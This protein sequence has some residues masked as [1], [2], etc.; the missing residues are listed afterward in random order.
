M[1]A[2][3]K[4]LIC[5]IGRSGLSLG[6]SPYP[7]FLLQLIHAKKRVGMNQEKNELKKW[8]AYGI[9]CRMRTISSIKREEKK[10]LFSKKELA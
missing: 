7:L 8:Y 5:R 3:F 6:F 10:E 9:R 4:I 2:S 1:R